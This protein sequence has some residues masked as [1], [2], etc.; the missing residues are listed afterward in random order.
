MTKDIIADL[1]EDGVIGDG[2]KVHFAEWVENK[3]IIFSK[4]N[5]NKIE[6]IYGSNFF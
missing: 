4:E 3:N 1:T 2:R 5:L 6:F